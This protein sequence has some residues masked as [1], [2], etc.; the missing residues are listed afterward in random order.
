MTSSRG[1]RGDLSRAAPGQTAFP[2]FRSGTSVMVWDVSSSCGTV[3]GMPV[4]LRFPT[5][6][7]SSLS[8]YSSLLSKGYDLNTV[9]TKGNAELLC[10]LPQSQAGTSR[11]S[12]L[13]PQALSSFS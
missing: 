2:A 3:W 9:L 10:V 13:R 1:A 8:P 7:F 4:T 12:E 5:L 6:P 11:C